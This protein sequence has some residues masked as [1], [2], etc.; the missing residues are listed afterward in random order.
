MFEAGKWKRLV[1]DEPQE[2]ALRSADIASFGNTLGRMMQDVITFVGHTSYVFKSSLFWRD[3]LPTSQGLR[4]GLPALSHSTIRL[5][6][7][8]QSAVRLHWGMQGLS[9][10]GELA[11]FAGSCGWVS[12]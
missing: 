5:M 10:I 1:I 11:V 12:R 3:C 9:G 2:T 7:A 8:F 6:R 4:V